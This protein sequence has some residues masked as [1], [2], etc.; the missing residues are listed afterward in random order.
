VSLS[1]LISVPSKEPTKQLRD[2]DN[3]EGDLS[4][5]YFAFKENK[6]KTE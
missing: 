6:E 3:A 4:V 5:L 2:K 1:H